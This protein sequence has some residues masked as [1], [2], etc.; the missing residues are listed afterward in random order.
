MAEQGKNVQPATPL[1][2]SMSA[3]V[4]QLGANDACLLEDTCLCTRGTNRIGKFT[5]GHACMWPTYRK[6]DSI[7]R[8]PMQR[9]SLLQPVTTQKHIHEVQERPNL[10][11]RKLN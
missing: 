11:N 9:Q 10:K 5:N 4:T 7:R 3:H 6:E 2:T 8:H 1:V